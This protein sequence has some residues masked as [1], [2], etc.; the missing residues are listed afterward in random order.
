MLCL[1]NVK[2]S[3]VLQLC[4]TAVSVL[5]EGQLMHKQSNHRAVI[6]LEKIKV[7]SSKSSQ[8]ALGVQN[9]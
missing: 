3:F 5:Y 1:L 2:F 8:F 9:Q 6:S 7:C 4:T